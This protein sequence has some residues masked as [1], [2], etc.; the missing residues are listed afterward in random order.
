MSEGAD[1]D[2]K[3]TDRKLIPEADETAR[4]RTYG[5]ACN[6]SELVLQAIKDTKV[7][8]TVW[9]GAYVGDNTTVK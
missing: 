4:I 9:L 3:T 5:S 1:S 8:M 2:R 7:N 6:Q